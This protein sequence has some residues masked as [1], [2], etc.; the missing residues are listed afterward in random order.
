MQDGTPPDQLS[1][2]SARGSLPDQQ[3]DLP[4]GANFEVS[5]KLPQGNRRSCDIIK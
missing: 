1:P 3:P 4:S 5:R 2:L